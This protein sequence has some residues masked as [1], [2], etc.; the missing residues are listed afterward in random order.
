M[1]VYCVYTLESPHWGDSNVY[2]Q[3]TIFQYEKEKTPL[4]IPNL[5]LWDF[6]QGTQDWVRKS[7]GKRA[8]SF[9]PLKFYCICGSMHSQKE[10][11]LTPLSTQRSIMTIIQSKPHKH[12]VSIDL[13]KYTFTKII[14]LWTYSPATCPFST[15]PFGTGL[16]PCPACNICSNLARVACPCSVNSSTPSC[17]S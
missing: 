9:E 8:I 1:K 17:P 16:S 10:I 3:Y 12:F 4:I 7:R 5:Q 13:W 6:F 14:Q 15:L 11:K 2:T